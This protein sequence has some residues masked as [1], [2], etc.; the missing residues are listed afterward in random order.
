MPVVN[1]V[2]PHTFYVA[3]NIMF[4]LDTGG[5]KRVLMLVNKVEDAT[6]FASNDAQNYLT[7]V[8]ARAQNIQWT[9]EQLRLQQPL[10]FLR[11]PGESQGFVIKGV[12]YV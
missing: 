1:T 5:T 10:P 11:S 7:F 9:I 12:Q 4:D 3:F 8:S 6:V 2:K